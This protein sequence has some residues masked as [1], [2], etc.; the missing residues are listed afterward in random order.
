MNSHALAGFDR[1]VFIVAI[2]FMQIKCI[3]SVHISFQ[4]IITRGSQLFHTNQGYIVESF[5]MDK[6]NVIF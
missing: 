2:T 6:I 1:L 5:I 3:N 4:C